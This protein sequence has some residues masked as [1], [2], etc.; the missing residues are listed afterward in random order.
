[1]PNITDT[2]IISAFLSG[3]TNKTL[4]H[5]LG[6]KSP[7]TTKELFDITTSHVSGEE[8]VGA[9]FN[10]TRGKAKQDED[11]G[12]GASNRSKKKKKNKPR[13]G[14]LLVAAT[15]RKGKKVSTEGAPD[16]FEK[17]LERP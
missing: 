3:T 11:V 6:R 10:R 16:H 5:K 15:E 7:R 1:L 2:N 17:M 4:V 9:I 12:E 14:D 13:S 8:V